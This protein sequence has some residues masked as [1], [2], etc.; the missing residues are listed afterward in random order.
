MP[1]V[2]LCRLTPIPLKWTSKL[3]GSL[4][5]GSFT[6]WVTRN[7]LSRVGTSP[8]QSGSLSNQPTAQYPHMNCPSELFLACAE[9]VVAS[10]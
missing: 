10:G 6:T 4:Y 2:P 7:L 5:V 8:Q 1:A 3:P 9:S